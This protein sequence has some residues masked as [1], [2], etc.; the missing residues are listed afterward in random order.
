MSVGPIY[1]PIYEPD[2]RR[3]PGAYAYGQGAVRLLVFR[4]PPMGWRSVV[5]DHEVSMGDRRQVYLL[6]M[7][8]RGRAPAVGWA[9]YRDEAVRLAGLQPPPR[10]R[11]GSSTL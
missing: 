2:G 10:K 1:E 3:V 4:D 6:W 8:R 7:R 11:R 5:V 9:M